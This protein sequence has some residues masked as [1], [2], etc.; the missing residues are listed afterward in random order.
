M[1]TTGYSLYIGTFV[2]YTIR[3]TNTIDQDKHQKNRNIGPH[4]FFI[5]RRRIFF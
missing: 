4:I 1:I 3:I 2:A 5:A